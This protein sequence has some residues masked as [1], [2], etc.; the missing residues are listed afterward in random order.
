MS[1][2]AEIQDVSPTARP[3]GKA[4]PRWVWFP[5]LWVATLIGFCL[6][7]WGTDA[8]PGLKN[9][10]IHIAIVLGVFGISGW[11]VTA[12]GLERRRR[13]TLGFV[14]LGLVAA[15]YLQLL[16]IEMVNNGDVGIVGWRWRWADPDRSL[17]VPDTAVFANLDWRETPQDYPAFLNGKYWAEVE[18]VALET[19]WEARPPKLRWKQPIGAGWSAFAIVGDY[20]V[21]QEQRG[22][23]EL[24]V[25]YEVKT[26]KV[27]WTHADLVRWDPRGN[28]ALGGVGPRA[29]PTVHEGRIFA[30]GAT[31][32]LN[33]IDARTGK[34][35]WSHDTI[36]EQDGEVV[37]WGKAGSPLIID[38]RVVISVGGPNKGSLVAYNMDSGKQAWAAG[39]RQSSYAT[40]VL[41][42]LVGVR[43]ILS[44]DEDFLTAHRAEDGEE[45][46]E[47][48][49]PSNSGS[50][51]AAAQPV[52][53]GEDRVLLTKGYGLGADV[54]QVS[55][56]GEEFAAE[57]VWKKQSVLKN[58]MSNVLVR[59]G[60]AY[61]LDDVFLQC[62]DLKDGRQ[63]WKKRRS[64]SFG[65]GQ[66]LLVGDAIVVL[67]EAGELILVEASPKKYHEL[68]SL[69]A[70]EGVTW[71]NPALSGPLL[72]IRNGEQAA[73]FEL[74]LREAADTAL[75]DDVAAGN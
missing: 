74:P 62:V 60:F 47:F 21:T 70:I 25:C 68:A 56:D 11:A 1:A 58:K 50:S 49:W 66:I 39:N 15:Y 51:A 65:H 54:I 35:L 48:E 19:D 73:C 46:W 33:C 2:T 31:G 22:N 57:S 4:R 44:V 10:V 17:T 61:G 28:G 23:Q 67:S 52:P 40:P 72:L 26:G 8:D 18:G 71:N 34:L 7:L 41:T 3:T 14:P 45:L 9:T 53:L 59:D 30:H 64:P 55:R 12:S 32:I 27:A 29:T 37:T 38:G 6:W 20:A 42:T 5:I 63:A 24:V 16:P 13:W 43:Q 36:A 75:S 69:Q